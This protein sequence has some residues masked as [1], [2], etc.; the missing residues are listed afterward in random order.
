ARR[1]YAGR[2]GSAPFRLGL[3]TAS[4]SWQGL[5]KRRWCHARRGRVVG[6]EAQLIAE[7]SVVTTEYSATWQG[8]LAEYSRTKPPRAAV[9]SSMVVMHH[10]RGLRTRH[11]L[12]G[13]DFA[14]AGDDAVVQ[15]GGQDADDGVQAVD[16]VIPAGAHA[17]RARVALELLDL[18]LGGHGVH[19]GH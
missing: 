2:R 3:R 7:R 5:P 13:L 19:A 16:A 9:K 6:L 17:A 8:H 18:G 14:L 12:A 10:L 15:V 4:K 11:A 1:S